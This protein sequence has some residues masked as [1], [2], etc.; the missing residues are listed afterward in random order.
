MKK[1]FFS[2]KYTL[3]VLILLAILGVDVILHK[4]IS[5]VMLPETFTEKRKPS[6]NKPACPSTLISSSKSWQKAVN[7]A[8]MALAID[9]ALGGIELDVYFDTS[10]T[11]FFVY[12]DSSNISDTKLETVLEASRN[13]E[14]SV[15]LDFKNLNSSNVAPSLEHLN[16]IRQQF[17]LEDKMIVESSKAEL[18]SAFCEQGFYTSYYTP[19]FNPYQEDEQTLLSFIDS[20]TYA[21]KK[22]KVNSLSGYY[23]QAPFLRKYFPNFPILT[24]TDQPSLSLVAN[25]FNRQLLADEMIPVVLYPVDY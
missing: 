5:R 14:V 21:T 19:F 12:H 16:S 7:S 18:L 20:I 6:A 8:Q 4:G 9:T 22:Y 23:F 10:K 13:K 15:W 3:S 11:I 1:G 25:V 17:N 24:W 2:N